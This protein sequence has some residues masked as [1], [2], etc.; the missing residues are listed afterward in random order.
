MIPQNIRSYLISI[1][2]SL[3][4]VACAGGGGGGG[5]VSTGP[6]TSKTAIGG[7]YDSHQISKTYANGSSATLSPISG[8]VTTWGANHITR[9]DTY[10]YS[11]GDTQS[12]AL[13]FSP[14]TSTAALT[15]ATYPGNWTTT[16]TVTAPSVS[17]VA[18]TYGDGYVSTSQ[19]GS[20]SKPFTQATLS[21]QSITDPSSYVSSS[22]TTYNLNWG[23]PDKNGP[24][25]ANLFPSA[26]NT[27]SSALSYA[28]IS[29]AGQTT[30]GPTLLQPSADVLAA[31]NNG[32]TGKGSNI[33]LIDNYANRAGCS[34]ANGN[35]HGVVTMM[36][37]DLI[38]PGASK[39]GLDYA[40]TTNFTGTAFDINGTN[41]ISSKSINVINMSWSFIYSANNWNC[42]NGCGTAPTNVVYNAGISSLAN[43][44]TNLN[45]VLNGTSTVTNLT[46]FANA[47]IVQSAGN[48]ALD[49]KYNLNA[50]GLSGDTNIQGRLLVVGAL[51]KNGTVAS[52]ATIASYSNTAGTNTSISDRFVV[53]NGT[54]PW[55][56]GSVKING[57][58]FPANYSGTSFAAPQVAG[59]TAI[60]MQKF[61]NLSASN[62]SNIILDTARTDTLSCSPSCDPTIYGKG[63]ASLSRALAPVG[64]LR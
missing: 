11:D 14:T 21:A 41:L 4:L 42:N 45:S 36:N 43:T 54:M 52:P 44:Y 20:S 48:D 3:A 40:F 30:T 34:Y 16:G 24:G 37:T 29:V 55:N 17:P 7:F 5:V 13:D 63:E 56:A 10:T 31:W 57:S 26:S 59:Y 33:L 28:G 60:V 1:F 64:R 39:Y 50:L 12:W 51:N 38:A 15:A 23:T 19:D 53:A 8:P 46:N 61:P 6:V 22:T 18:T 27:L 47:V 62:T 35:C 9:T 49:S 58:N 32:W 2:L 25:Y